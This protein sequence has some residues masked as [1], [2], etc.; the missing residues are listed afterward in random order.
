MDGERID[1]DRKTKK[2]LW[3]SVAKTT[4]L[5]DPTPQQS[6]QRISNAVRDMLSGFPPQ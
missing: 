2:L 6:A 4:L 5:K 3:R 1:A